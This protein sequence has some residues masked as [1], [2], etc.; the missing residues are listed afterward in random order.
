[1][2][3]GM[4]VQAKP[5]KAVRETGLANVVAATR[6]IFEKPGHVDDQGAAAHVI[7]PDVFLVSLK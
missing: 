3:C 5:N 6:A 7:Q 2:F 1:M 4:F